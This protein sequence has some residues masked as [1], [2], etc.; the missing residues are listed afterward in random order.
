MKGRLQVEYPN[1]DFD[2][3]K[4]RKYTYKL[5]SDLDKRGYLFYLKSLI[6]KKINSE[7]NH[8][9][10]ASDYQL[11]YKINKDIESVNQF[12]QEE[13][14]RA[15]NDPKTT[16]DTESLFTVKGQPDFNPIPEAEKKSVG[17]TLTDSLNWLHKVTENMLQSH[18][19]NMLINSINRLSQ[20]LSQSNKQKSEPVTGAQPEQAQKSES[21]YERDKAKDSEKPVFIEWKQPLYL[22]AADARS[23][24]DEEH[25]D[26]TEYYKKYANKYLFRG[27]K[28]THKQLKNA[29]DQARNQGKVD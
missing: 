1:F 25:I 13:F 20:T 21:E 3:L 6:L 2:Y 15:F 9:K 17:G 27:K 12:I 14:N 24:A 18:R 23:R 19:Q 28:I 11:L 10:T 4:I 8:D 26:Y 29:Y 5:S 22:L 16:A 7:K